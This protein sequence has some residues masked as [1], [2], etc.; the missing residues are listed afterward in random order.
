MS[1]IVL[2]ND[3]LKAT[4]NTFGGLIE[5]LLDKKTGLEH[6]WKYDSALWPRR[7]AVCFPFCGKCKDG[8]YSYN[9]KEYEIPNHGFA[10]ERDF[11]VLCST[12][13]HLILED[14]FDQTT[15]SQYPFKYSLQIEYTLE[16]ASFKVKYHVSN[17]GQEPMYYSI[18]SHY[19]YQL[20]LIQTS[21]ALWFSKPQ[22]AGGLNLADGSTQPDILQGRFVVPFPGLVDNDSFILNLKDL[23]SSWVGVGDLKK[24]F[25]K[26]SGD[27]FKYVVIWAPVGGK[28]PFMCI[29]F[30]DGM[31]DLGIATGKIEEKFAINKLEI[32]QTKQYLQTITM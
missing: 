24:V 28:N 1:I 30:W 23:D 9:G 16:G 3:N 15:L 14:R 29:E 8:K 4:L 12:S 18:G 31:A 26:V 19:T 20:P 22:H 7:T 2:E 13:T 32:G 17:E 10:R 27:G 11:T 25:T 21:C 5:G 6:A